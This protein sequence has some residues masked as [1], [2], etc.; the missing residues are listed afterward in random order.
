MTFNKIKT[1]FTFSLLAL[2]V[3]AVWEARKWSIQ[4][5]LMPLLIGIPTVFLLG[6]QLIRE[7]WAEDPPKANSTDVEKE[8]TPLGPSLLGGL[9]TPAD[10]AEERRRTASILFWIVGFALGIWLLG[11]QLGITL[12]TLF[13]LK[14]A[15]RESWLVSASITGAVW[16]STM[17]LFDCTM[18]IFFAEGKL[19]AWLG[20]SLNPFYS[21]TCHHFMG[22]FK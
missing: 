15:A 9:H 7:L 21:A 2:A 14:G 11:F 8:T 16:A 3:F 1:L 19:F 5:S 20:L 18:H 13:Y 22:F 6:L 10:P 17:L 12:L 4:A